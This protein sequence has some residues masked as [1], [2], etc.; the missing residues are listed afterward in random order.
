MCT[1]LGKLVPKL[2]GVVNVSYDL[3]FRPMIAHWKG[4]FDNYT[5]CHQTLNMS[6]VWLWQA[7][8]TLFRAPKRPW[9]YR[10]MYW[11]EN[12]QNNPVGLGGQALISTW[13]LCMASDS[14][15]TVELTIT[16]NYTR[17][18]WTNNCQEEPVTIGGWPPISTWISPPPLGRNGLHCIDFPHQVRKLMLNLASSE[19][20]A[21][22]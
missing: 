17:T 15:E 6:T 16:K 7:K 13:K 10:K 21:L 14:P 9:K 5:L 22:L 18:C 11:H 20:L 12:F 19:P 4:I 1:S 3:H 8:K 2:P